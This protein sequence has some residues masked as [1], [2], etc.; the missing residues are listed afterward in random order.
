M[1]KVTLGA[2]EET[3]KEKPF[4]KLMR[5]NGKERLIVLFHEAESGVVLLSETSDWNTGEY[6]DKF[7]MG[8]WVDYNEP[9]TIQNA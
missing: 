4:P 7:D 8:Q 6:Y 1:I 5:W 2:E 3:P 9:I